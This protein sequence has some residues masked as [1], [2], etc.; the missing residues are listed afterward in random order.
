MPSP[1]SPSK[2]PSQP[3]PTAVA[4]ALGDAAPPTARKRTIPGQ[5]SVNARTGAPNLPDPLGGDVVGERAVAPALAPGKARGAALQDEL[6]HDT[7][8]GAGG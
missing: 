8:C 2:P 5:P 1:H 4:P 7:G 3:S 6:A